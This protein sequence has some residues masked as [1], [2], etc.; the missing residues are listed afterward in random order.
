MAITFER[1]TDSR[2]ITVKRDGIVQRTFDVQDN[3]SILSTKEAGV[4]N[5]NMVRMLNNLE[6]YEFDWREVT[7]TPTPGSRNELVQTLILNFFFDVGLIGNTPL[8]VA[9]YEAITTT[10]GQITKPTGS[11]I[12]LDQW[13]NGVDALVCKIVGGKPDFEDSGVDVLTF[14]VDGNY[15]IS[16]ALPSN[17]A[18]LIFYLS[19]PLKFMGNLDIN[20]TIQYVELSY[21]GLDH[22]TLINRDVAGNHTLV[23]PIAD[24]TT[25]FMMQKADGTPIFIFDSTSE[26]ISIAGLLDVLKQI[27]LGGTD[28]VISDNGNINAYGSRMM[29]FADGTLYDMQ[30]TNRVSIDFVNR[31]LQRM[32]T[33]TGTSNDGSTRILQGNNSDNTTVFAVDTNGFELDQYDDLL[34]SAQWLATSGAPSPDLVTATIGGVVFSLWAFDGGNTAESMTSYFEVIHGIDI[35]ILNADTLL[36]EIHT[37]GMPSTNAAGVVKV[38]F[39]IVYLPVGGVPQLLGTFSTLITIALNQQ[40]FHKLGGVEIPKPTSG[41]GIGDQ[42]LVKYERKPN[43]AQDTYGADWLFLQCALHMPFNSRGSRQRYVK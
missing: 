21:T 32:W 38:F 43:D 29:S 12:L 10:S 7:I 13:S 24:S 5:P 30:A 15:T 8:K 9:Y 41:Y 3:V 34:P 19:V 33:I 23:K 36:A 42:I 39:S 35:D 16:A 40:Y 20:Y 1:L 25:A 14:D 31:I 28:L 22:S 26:S 2:K 17:P 4:E 27:S 18:A 11:T 6:V 37:H